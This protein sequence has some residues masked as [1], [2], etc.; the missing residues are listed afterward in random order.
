M[1]FFLQNAFLR[2]AQYVYK[3][4]KNLINRF[5]QVPSQPL[6]SVAVGGQTSATSTSN[7]TSALEKTTA[8]R[9]ASSSHRLSPFD[10]SDL[11]TRIF[12]HM[13]LGENRWL[14][15]VSKSFLLAWEYAAKLHLFHSPVISTL[16]IE[17]DI[18]LYDKQKKE[19]DFLMEYKIVILER[20]DVPEIRKAFDKLAAF[21]ENKDPIAF[22]A[23][24]T[25][26]NTIN[27]FIIRKRIA[28]TQDDLND[29][30]ESNN[31]PGK[32]NC[33]Y[34]F[35]TR[36]PE[37]VLKDKALEGFW[38]GLTE[39]HLNG[40]QLH[41]LPDAIELLSALETLFVC[42]NKLSFLPSTIGQLSNLID[43]KVST[44]KLK[45]LPETIGKLNSLKWLDVSKNSLCSLPE[46]IGDLTA[47][48]Y[49]Y[50][51]FNPLGALPNT[52]GNLNEL[53]ELEVNHTQLHAL[54]DT[55]GQLKMLRILY[56][57]KCKLIALPD[58]I[59][60]CAALE[61]LYV[62][63]NYLRKIPDELREDILHDFLNNPINKQQ[64]LASQQQKPNEDNTTELASRPKIKN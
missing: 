32:L 9:L 58:T 15:T 6:V 49:L 44:N 41:A 3:A 22:Y 27:E 29:S 57:N 24:E 4:I 34:S 50:V 7:E 16:G 31:E 26:L 23:R 43:L 11:T 30:G 59:I 2:A 54:P 36:F 13:P 38:R 53:E 60:E 25:H 55:I 56:A 48:S 17:N 42:G 33:S 8:A 51:D 64:C 46:T 21:K 52:I 1:R 62:V 28:A 39:L 18:T 10:L 37:S 19:I 20:N 47:L 5:T 45:V 63:Q 12:Q 40:N 35:L 61:E 14:R